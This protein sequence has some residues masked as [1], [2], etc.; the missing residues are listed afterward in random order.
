M[1]T[2]QFGV[3]HS[4]TEGCIRRAVGEGGVSRAG[5]LSPA[6]LAGS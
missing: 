2:R 3:K 5:Q 1:S 6:P 4:I